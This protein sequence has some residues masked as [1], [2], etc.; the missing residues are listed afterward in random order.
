[1]QEAVPHDRDGEIS[2]TAIVRAIWQIHERDQRP[3]SMSQLAL[4]T[5]LSE[6]NIRHHLLVLQ[7]RGVV[8]N[9]GG[10]HGWMLVRATRP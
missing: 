7:Q 3:P 2:R 1:M 6:T 8:R 4:A 5:G 9:I 10:A